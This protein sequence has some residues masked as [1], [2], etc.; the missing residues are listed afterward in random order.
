MLHCIRQC[1]ERLLIQ[2]F[3]LLFCALLVLGTGPVL[4]QREEDHVDAEPQGSRDADMIMTGTKTYRKILGIPTQEIRFYYHSLPTKLQDSCDGITVLYVGVGTAMDV[5]SYDNLSREVVMQTNRRD[6]EESG[7]V[8]VMI[9][10]ASKNIPF[11]LSGYASLANAVYGDMSTLLAP[12]LV[13]GIEIERCDPRVVIGGHSASGQAAI[14]DLVKGAFKFR[15]AAFL[16]LDPFS[17]D[18]ARTKLKDLATLS[19]GFT[20]ETCFVTLKVAAEGAY[21]ATTNTDQRVLY[22]IQNENEKESGL[23]HCAFTDTGCGGPSCPHNVGWYPF[24]YQLVG[25]AANHLVRALEASTGDEPLVFDREVFAAITATNV[26]V[27]VGKEEP[28]KLRARSAATE[29]R[30]LIPVAVQRVQHTAAWLF[31]A[32]LGGAWSRTRGLF[33]FGRAA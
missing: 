27:F 26:T 11:K 28:V 22:R 31:G 20:T 7:P 3:V 5:N 6:D 10:D 30:R 21:Q 17:V 4:A 32:I 18:P 29:R 14:S 33:A 23:R 16:G 24:V 13:P 19:V 15:P 8:V 1:K 9:A 12:L 2:H 25:E